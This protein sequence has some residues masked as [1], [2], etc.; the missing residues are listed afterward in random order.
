MPTNFGDKMA[1][2]RRQHLALL[3][4]PTIE[5]NLGENA[6]AAAIPSR[7]RTPNA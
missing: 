5:A 4:P 7:N 3:V 6:E 1:L 2:A